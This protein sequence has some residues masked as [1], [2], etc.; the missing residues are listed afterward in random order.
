[1]KRKVIGFFARL[2]SSS[3]LPCF[4]AAANM[5]LTSDTVPV[6]RAADEAMSGSGT[7]SLS[8]SDPC[9]IIGHGTKFTSELKPKWQIMLPK[10]LNSMVAEVTEVISD[11]ELRIKKEFGGESGKGTAKF[12]DAL[13]ETKAKGAQGLEFRRLPFIDQQVMYQFVYQR[14]KDGGCIGIFPEGK[15][16][17]KLFFIVLRDLYSAK[18]GVTT[19]R[20]YCL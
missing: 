4:F 2:M 8:E 3:M 5:L 12:R 10:S 17:A 9:L 15:L 14:L 18:V 6:A 13:K 16:I 11:T 20:T 7:I 1:M 19:E